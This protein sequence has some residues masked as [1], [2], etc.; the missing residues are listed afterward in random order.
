MVVW[1]NLDAIVTRV[2]EH[3]DAG[4]DHVLI[5]AW[6]PTLSKCLPTSGGRLRP[7]S[8]PWRPASAANPAAARRKR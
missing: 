2:R 4:A 1:G 8:P 6:A 5:Q 7:R 3:L